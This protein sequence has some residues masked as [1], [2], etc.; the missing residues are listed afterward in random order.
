MI[1]YTESCR[2]SWAKMLNTLYYEY[3]IPQ[4]FCKID[5]S[6]EGS[7]Y[8]IMFQEF[9]I[10]NWNPGWLFDATNNLWHTKTSFFY[11]QVEICLHHILHYTIV[12]W[13]FLFVIFYLVLQSLW[14]YYKFGDNSLYL[15]FFELLLRKCRM[16]MN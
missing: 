1:N 3:T 8:L 5:L 9:V 12:G 7:S 14:L 16:I 15:L 10:G 11:L 2:K 6:C 4:I 13:E